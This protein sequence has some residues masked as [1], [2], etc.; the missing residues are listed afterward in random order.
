MENESNLSGLSVVDYIQKYYSD[1]RDILAILENS[2]ARWAVMA[3]RPQFTKRDPNYR[4][5]SGYIPVLSAA[6]EE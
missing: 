5:L 4:T 1:K 6:E 2:S 3:N